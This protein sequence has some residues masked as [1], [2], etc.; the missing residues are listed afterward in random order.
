MLEKKLEEARVSRRNRFIVLAAGFIG[1][2][3]LCGVIVFATGCCNNKPDNTE[4]IFND[5]VASTESQIITESPSAEAS[6]PDELLRESFIDA[7]NEY[8][9]V[10]E[11]ELEKI[12]FEEWDIPGYKR[13]ATLK[14]DALSKFS[15]SDYEAALNQIETLTQLAQATIADSQE[16]FAQAL[17]KAEESY[18]LDDFDNAKS[19]ILKALMLDNTSGE[20]TFLSDKIEVLGNILPLLEEASIAKVENDYQK[21]LGIVEKIIELSPDRSGAIERKAQLVEKIRND[22]FNRNISQSYKAIKQGDATLARKKLS[23]AK[24]IFPNRKEI[25]N[26]AS[27]LQ[28]FEKKQRFEKHI[29]RSQEAI[30]ADDWVTVKQQLQLALLEQDADKTVQDT[31]TIADNIIGLSNSFDQQIA[32]PY[33]LSNKN[34]IKKVEGEIDT[35]QKYFEYSPS[36]KNKTE[37]LSK[38]VTE[39]N[40]KVMVKVVSDNQTN[41]LVRGVGVV[42]TTESKSIQL[43]PGHYTFEGK[44]KGYKSKLVDVLIPYDK[45]SHH[46]TIICDEPI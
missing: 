35:A 23:A 44:R 27:A 25:N 45:A 3:L 33:R 38:L 29:L 43:K 40:K 11:P 37:Q 6:V 16:E 9:S 26:V 31:I 30:K 41:I 7:L 1:I 46:L 28:K 39:M 2:A 19:N 34:T 21:E 32:N 22:D 15:L 20:A 8:E 12:N 10:I 4:D 5:T 13:L 14:E 24:K 42:G 17:S 18:Q 36:L